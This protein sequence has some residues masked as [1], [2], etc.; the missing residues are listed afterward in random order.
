MAQVY[1]HSSEVSGPWV[2]STPWLCLYSA[3]L[4]C[5]VHSV[6]PYSTTSVHTLALGED[7][8]GK[9]RMCFIHH[10]RSHTL[11]QSLVT[12]PLLQG[13]GSVVFIL[14]SCFHLR[15]VGSISAE[16]RENGY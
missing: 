9:E 2:P 8:T 16:E 12:W 3:V 14:G 6:P 4:S 15:I 5:K 11:G 13:P 7:V 1:C 10:F